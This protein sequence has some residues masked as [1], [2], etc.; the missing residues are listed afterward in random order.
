M[1]GDTLGLIVYVSVVD[2]DDNVLIND[3]WTVGMSNGVWAGMYVGKW[4]SDG[5]IVGVGII[6]GC[7]LFLSIVGVTTT[8]GLNVGGVENIAI[9]VFEVLWE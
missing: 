5:L 4:N 1:E 2:V 3:G 6:L 9:V 7:L 8:G